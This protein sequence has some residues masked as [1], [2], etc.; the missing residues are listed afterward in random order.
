MVV[1]TWLFKT[2]SKVEVVLVVR[3]PDVLD[4]EVVRDIVSRVSGR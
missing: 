4:E 3:R 1:V 2:F